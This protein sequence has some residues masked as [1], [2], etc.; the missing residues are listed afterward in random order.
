MAHLQARLAMNNEAQHK[1]LVEMTKRCNELA[2]ILYS[3]NQDYTFDMTYALE[4][5]TRQYEDYT[6]QRMPFDEIVSRLNLEIERY[7]HLAEALRRL[8]PILDKI[9]LIPDSLSAVMDTIL[10]RESMHHHEDGFDRSK[11]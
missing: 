11:D 8:P 1:Q 6:K 9:D 7:E 2:L 4:E 10:M 3:Q 5:V